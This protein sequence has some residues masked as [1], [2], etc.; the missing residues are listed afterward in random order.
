M[1]LRVGKELLRFASIGAQMAVR[2]AFGR[3]DGERFLQN[4]LSGMPG[5][6]AKIGQLLGMRDASDIP[7]PEPM[8]IE[9][10][11]AI[12]ARESPLLAE[13]VESLSEWSKTASLGQTH[14]ALLRSGERVAIKVQYPDVA[15]SLAAQIDAIFGVAG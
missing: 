5:A 8:P 4:T 11:K 12:I 3:D 13:A 7:S 10:I 1:N 9:D 15:V 14:Q 6:P 2:K